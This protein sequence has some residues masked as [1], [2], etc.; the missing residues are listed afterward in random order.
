MYFYTFRER[1]LGDYFMLYSLGFCAILPAFALLCLCI[2]R[3]KKRIGRNL[4][5]AGIILFS[6]LIFFW[7]IP[8]ISFSN[9]FSLTEAENQLAEAQEYYFKYKYIQDTHDGMFTFGLYQELEQKGF[10]DKVDINRVLENKPYTS[11]EYSNNAEDSKDNLLN[12]IWHRISQYLKESLTNIKEFIFRLDRSDSSLIQFILVPIYTFIFGLALW[13][14]SRRFIHIPLYRN[15]LENLSDR[16][17]EVNHRWLN[18]NSLNDLLLPSYVSNSQYIDPVNLSSILK[19]QGNIYALLGNTGDGKTVGMYSAISTIIDNLD[20]TRRYKT[21]SCVPLL[22]KFSELIEMQDAY[23]IQDQII[24]LLL[25]EK[26]AVFLGKP[27]RLNINRL[28]KT[29]ESDLQSGRFMFFLDG[30]DEVE[31]S[32]RYHITKIFVQVF[33][34]YPKCSC[35][36]GAREN[37]FRDDGFWRISDSHELRL[38]PFT[39]DMVWTFL[40]KWDYPKG[41]NSADLYQKIKDNAQLCQLSSCPLLLTLICY[42]YSKSNLISPNSISEFYLETVK[43]FL[44]N[45]ER[46]KGIPRRNTLDPDLL[47]DVSAALSYRLVSQGK[48]ECRKSEMLQN[49]HDIVRSKGINSQVV[50]KD[51]ARSQ[52]VTESSRGMCR[53]YHRSF[54]EF[55]SAYYCYTGEG[56]FLHI[57]SHPE[58]VIFFF[59]LQND[60][61]LALKYMDN[62]D[63]NF[64]LMQRLFLECTITDENR[65]KSFFSQCIS[66]VS[67]ASRDSLMYLVS[68]AKKYSIVHDNLVNYFIEHLKICF[69]PRQI[70]N[71]L[72]VLA[73][74]IPVNEFGTLL[75]EYVR[76]INIRKIDLSRSINSQELFLAILEADIEINQKLAI[77]EMIAKTDNQEMLLNLLIN[78]KSDEARGIVAI[79]LL[80]CFPHSSIVHRCTERAA[81]KKIKWLT[82]MPYWLIQLTSQIKFNSQS[83]DC[84]FISGK[85]MSDRNKIEQYCDK[86]SWKWSHLHAKEKFALFSVVFSATKV[87]ANSKLK[88]NIY[89]LSNRIKFLCAYIISDLTDVPQN[90]LIIDSGIQLKD[91]E[92]FRL[93]WQRKSFFYSPVLLTFISRILYFITILISL[94]IILCQQYMFQLLQFEYDSL[95]WEAYDLISHYLSPFLSADLTI[96][97]YIN[98]NSEY[99]IFFTAWSICLW[100][101]MRLLLFCREGFRMILFY[102]LSAMVSL[103]SFCSI[104]SSYWLRW[105]AC[106]FV[107]VSLCVTI[108]IGRRDFR[109][110]CDPQFTIIS[111]YLL[112]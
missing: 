87:M 70:E 101:S 100:A 24:D 81:F 99:I 72:T 18:N 37:V 31:Q 29:I 58:V 56:E 67:F 47:L 6:I 32:D 3:L 105:P 62:S 78:A 97:S 66:A 30:Y 90:Q 71:I 89:L 53:F 74:L 61:N 102:L 75:L 41:K 44:G 65:I 10:F 95:Y 13:I 35:V 107:L 80:Y 38:A 91:V 22:F 93:H 17:L 68:F 33:H 12:D 9:I 42:L 49:I 98:P 110:L 36:I 27:W 104:V 48:W 40:N 111:R 28:K 96:S 50:W 82:E 69:H 109:S 15:Y 45:W 20:L 7:T 77:V 8:R 2:F 84:Y 60:S 59:S 16:T 14:V 64:V 54:Q 55:L 25:S 88:I 21:P 108:W 1:I 112:E 94:I 92:E 73:Y 86:Y 46:E 103:C 83:S 5:K 4:A 106:L 26:Q 39:L 63:I 43:C 19:S 23:S 52:L 85:S 34:M 11:L 51:L 79:G 76:T 57:Q